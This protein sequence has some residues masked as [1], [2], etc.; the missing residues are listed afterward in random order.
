M[1]GL[2]I[3]KPVHYFAGIHPTLAPQAAQI[4][5][6]SAPHL[7]DLAVWNG[8]S[9]VGKESIHHRNFP[10]IKDNP[11][12][13]RPGVWEEIEASMKRDQEA[14]ER[15]QLAK[16]AAEERIR[17]ERERQAQQGA[18]AKPVKA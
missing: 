7:V 1:D 17:K 5:A 18:P 4:V 16:M 11:A 9:Y 12:I 15:I 2:Y 13:A 6:I 14:V 10:A 8:N 3:G